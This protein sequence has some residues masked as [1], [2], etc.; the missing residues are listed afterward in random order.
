MTSVV[1]TCNTFEDN[2]EIK[3]ILIKYLM[4]SCCIGYDIQFNTRIFQNKSSLKDITNNKSGYFWA[5]P[6]N[7]Q[8]KLGIRRHFRT[9]SGK[10]QDIL[11]SL[12]FDKSAVLFESTVPT[13][14][15][16]T[17]CVGSPGTTA[18]LIATQFPRHG[19]MDNL[20]TERGIDSQFLL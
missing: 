2:F 3:Q 7:F 14:N 20:T 13:F 15:S 10:P 9:F 5:L 1:W 16:C 6:L 11:G 8:I 12:S 17:K 4:E 19:C 18:R